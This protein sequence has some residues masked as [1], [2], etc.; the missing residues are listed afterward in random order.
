MGIFQTHSTK[1]I[2][3]NH[4]KNIF[5]T[6]SNFIWNFTFEIGWIHCPKDKIAARVNEYWSKGAPLGKNTV[7]IT[8]CDDI[9]KFEKNQNNHCFSRL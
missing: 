7:L 1:I 4:F 2:I 6:R 9:A 5:V 8:P 3:H